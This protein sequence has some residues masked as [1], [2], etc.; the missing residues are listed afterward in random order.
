MVAMGLM[1]IA[2][3]SSCE[4]ILGEWD[5]PTPQIEVPQEVVTLGA[6]L[7]DGA[8]ITVTINI[9]GVPTEVTFKKVGNDY[10][11]QAPASTR[12]LTRA[13]SNPVYSLTYVEAEKQLVFSVKKS[14]GELVY[15]VSI[16]MQNNSYT[17]LAS[18]DPEAADYSYNGGLTVNNTDLSSSLTKDADADKILTFTAK[19]LAGNVLEGFTALT[20]LD[21][22]GAKVASAT[23]GD[24][25]LTV[26]KTDVSNADYWFEA[27]M[28]DGKKYIAK[29]NVDTSKP[30]D[31]LELA[32]WGN[33]IGNDGNF[34]ATAA[35]VTAAEKVA[36]AMIVYI[37]AD[38]DESDENT[39]YHG[40][41]MALTNVS[42]DHKWHSSVP[43]GSWYDEIDGDEPMNGLANTARMAAADLQDEAKNPGVAINGYSVEGFTPNDLGFSKWFIPSVG[44]FYKI[45]ESVS[46]NTE[47]TSHRINYGMML[48]KGDA[49]LTA[50]GEELVGILSN[51]Y[52]T[53]HMAWSIHPSSEWNFCIGYARNIKESGEMADAGDRCL[54]RP[55]IAF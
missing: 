35:A 19:D 4:D 5:K 14:T 54:I 44:Q 43:A 6:A 2:S 28:A 22:S 50:F 55:F 39:H 51:T 9:N 46:G 10:V 23:A 47:W 21:G 38:A 8:L 3:L 15:G 30:S 37:G 31:G 45:A 25:W 17:P 42:G 32:T 20:I 1:T 27:T 13:I 24:G 11:Y 29:K 34:Y 41:A 49:D 26:N 36:A 16:D 48:A 12:A 7:E 33:Y 40:L 52:D 53:R 18:S